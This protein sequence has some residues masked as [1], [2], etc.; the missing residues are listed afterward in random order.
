MYDSA[1][2]A[3]DATVRSWVRELITGVYGWLHII[4]GD[5]GSAWSV[6][7]GKALGYWHGLTAFVNSLVAALYHL[8][9]ILLPAVIA[10][11]RKLFG[12]AEKFITSVYNYVLRQVAS[13]IQFI[14]KSV[15]GL[16]QLVLRD[17]WR[18][19]LA[20]LT[21]AWKWIKTDGATVFYYISHPDKLI[22]LIW[23]YLI[24]KLEREAWN[25]GALLGK[26]FLSLILHNVKR[27]AL[28]IEDIINAVL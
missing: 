2:G 16:W 4:A 25:V 21:N 20:S 13:L 14:S 19:L 27:L 26:F 22:D 6:L 23:L 28:L 15:D 8:F 5:V 18:P 10:E 24:A 3:I 12:Q 7:E 11:Y 9:K 1:A 17:V